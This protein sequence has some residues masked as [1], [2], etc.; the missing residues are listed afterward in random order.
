MFNLSSQEKAII[1]F[2]SIALLVGSLVHY[3]KI[4]SLDSSQYTPTVIEKRII[5]SKIIDI[6]TAGV[7]DLIRLKGIGPVIA[8]Q[9]ILYRDKYGSFTS[10]ED[11]MKVKGI[12][13]KTF[14]KIKDSISTD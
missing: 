2:L 12:G 7:K 5:S 4:K 8:G 14:N 3:Y 11:I 13:P 9:I 10:K 1:A 6:N